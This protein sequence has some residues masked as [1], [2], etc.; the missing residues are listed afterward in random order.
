MCVCLLAVSKE[1]RGWDYRM[2]IHRIIKREPGMNDWICKIKDWALHLQEM[3]Y[4]KNVCRI[5]RES[6]L[7]NIWSRKREGEGERE[8]EGETE[9]ERQRKR[10][11]ERGRERKN[12]LSLD[13]QRKQNGEKAI[14]KA[15][16]SRT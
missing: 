10:D 6:C 3:S 15:V 13:L 16:L 11:R 12:K 4:P 2:L 7:E 8:R 9:R 5:A 14:W 1:S